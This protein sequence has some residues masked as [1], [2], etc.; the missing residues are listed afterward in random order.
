MNPH[1]RPF[2]AIKVV[3]IAGFVC[4]LSV[5][6]QLILLPVVGWH[7]TL[8]EA[9][10]MGMTVTGPVFIVGDSLR[11]FFARLGGR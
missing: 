6:L 11:G 9:L 10:H 2:C 1:R 3:A 4:A 7:P 5:A 8:P